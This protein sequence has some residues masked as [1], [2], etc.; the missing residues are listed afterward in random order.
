MPD[1]SVIV[2]NYNTKDL[3]LQCLKS[4]FEEESHLE[5]EVIVVDNASEDGSVEEIRNLKFKNKN[6]KSRLK[7]IVNKKNVGFSKANNQGIKIAKGRYILLLNSDTKVK[8][9]TISKLLEFAQSKKNAGA[10]APRLLNPDGTIQGSVFRLPTISL[11]IRQYWLGE[12]GLLDKHAPISNKPLEVESCVMAAFMITPQA[13]KRVG[14]LDERYFMYYEDLDFCR[15]IR[16][17]GLK[18][19]YLPSAEVIHYHG[20]SAR[21]IE[22]QEKQR[23]RLVASSKIYFG[24]L[25][26]YIFNFILWSGQKWQ[27]L[28]N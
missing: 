23:K 14:L 3:I 17:E 18:I 21:K 5:K 7:I 9:E 11:A 2:V 25:K 8:E 27:E 10:V 19:Y 1:V 28:R 6:Y 15:R 24:V 4:V 16:K 13:L 12:R 26:H 22:D 20:A